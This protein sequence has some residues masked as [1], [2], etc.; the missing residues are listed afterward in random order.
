MTGSCVAFRGSR[1]YALVPFRERQQNVWTVIFQP[2]TTRHLLLTVRARSA[3]AV[4]R[5][6]NVAGPAH[7]LGLRAV[8]PPVLG[9]FDNAL[10]LRPC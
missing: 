4:R 1:A 10:V 2:T 8:P 3:L 5:A 9:A 6:W 7:A